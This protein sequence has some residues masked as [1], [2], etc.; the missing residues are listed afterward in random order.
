MLSYNYGIDADKMSAVRLINYLAE[1]EDEHVTLYALIQ[2]V[3]RETQSI[4]AKQVEN[5]DTLI[6]ISYS[7][8]H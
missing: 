4:I 1:T 6:C 3:A 7:I 8:K 5:A 2:K